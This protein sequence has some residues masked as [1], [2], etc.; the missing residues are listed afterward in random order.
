MS[1]DHEAQR[2]AQRMPQAPA[3]HMIIEFHTTL[4]TI[5]KCQMSSERKFEREI[6]RIFLHTKP[7]VPVRTYAF[8]QRAMVRR[9]K[10]VEF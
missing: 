7:P 9:Y 8:A 1:T 10:R 2:M 3:R 5:E 6:Y 4:Y